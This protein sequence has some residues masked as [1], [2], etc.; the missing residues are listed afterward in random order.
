[1]PATPVTRARLAAA[2]Q[3]ARRLQAGSR[4]SK[5]VSNI[6]AAVTD[7]ADTDPGTSAVLQTVLDN[8]I[9]KIDA[10]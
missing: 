9:T 6:L 3:A 7:A 5:D 2:R 1:M 4:V 8:V 10:S